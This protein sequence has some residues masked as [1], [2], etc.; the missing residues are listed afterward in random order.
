MVK[1][2]RSLQASLGSHVSI[3]GGLAKAIERAGELGCNTL[4]CFGGNPRGWKQRKL[5]KA[6]ATDF[7]EARKKA[8]LNA[9]VIHASYLINLS[10]PD[11]ELFNRSIELLKIELLRA[12]EVGADF[13][14]IHLGSGLGSGPDFVLKRV[15]GAFKSVS[16]LLDDLSVELLLENTA[17]SGH[18]TGAKLTDIKAI[19]E[20]YEK[21]RNKGKG[22]KSSIGFC[23]DTCH[24]FAA[25]YPMKSKREALAFIDKVDKEI[26]LARL[27]VIHLNDS[28]GALASHLDRHE[29]I[30]EG[31]IG[32]TGFRAFLSDRRIRGIPLIL[33]TP[34]K[35]EADDPRNIA[36][37]KKMI[38]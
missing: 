31:M 23:L 9:V 26:G 22:K 38:K 1:E 21:G 2:G 6:E 16:K 24:A 8:G 7:R 3:A 28:K 32:L 33:E 27:K 36:V 18:T 12:D 37:V 17:G 34:K 35:S 13:L 15:V 30:G 19:I 10:S 5:T 4:Q 14:V 29:H 20:A 11:D 25:G